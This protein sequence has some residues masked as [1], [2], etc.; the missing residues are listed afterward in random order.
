[1]LNNLKIILLLLCVNVAFAQK[2][3]RKHKSDFKQVWSDEFNYKGLPDSTKW[4]YDVGEGDWGWGN[5]EQQYYTN[6]DI[7]NVMVKNG[8]LTITARKEKRGNKEYTSTRLITK[9]KADW[10]HGRIDFR[11]KLPAGRGT[12]PAGW[13]LGSNQD[14]VGWPQCGEV[15]VLEHVGFDP[16]TIVGSFHSTTYNHI[17]GTQK[18]QKLF[19]KNPYTTFHVY[20]CEWNAEKI[21]FLLDGK[22]YLTVFN[23]KISEKEWPFDKPL[24]ALVNLAI[25][26]N[27]GGAKGIDPNIFPARFEIDYVRVYQ[28]SKVGN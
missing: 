11:A 20:S 27:W 14:T 6:A 24:Y 26:G 13:M 25:G 23:E 19:I 17:K 7:N 12:W 5:N 3:P 8:V 15:D 22:A 18:T 21:S 2:K 1:M 10:S 16:D 9:G 4:G 28:K